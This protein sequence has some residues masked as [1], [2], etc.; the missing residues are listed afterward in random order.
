M[1]RRKG[2]TTMKK[3]LCTLLAAVM[4]ALCLLTPASAASMPKLFP[5]KVTGPNVVQSYVPNQT[6]GTFYMAAYD[7]TGRMVGFTAHTPGYDS[8]DTVYLTASGDIDRVEFFLLGDN[9]APLTESLTLYRR[10][11]SL[12]YDGDSP[13]TARTLYRKNLDKTF[14]GTMNEAEV[15]PGDLV[16][17]LANADGSVTAKVTHYELVQVTS[18]GGHVTLNWNGVSVSIVKKLFAR[19]DYKAGDYV[20]V[21]FNEDYTRVLDSY[22]TGTVSGKVTALKGGKFKIGS[23]FYRNVSD[24]EISLFDTVTVVLNRANQI[25]RV[26][27]QTTG[28][29]PDN[30]NPDIPGSSVVA[31]TSILAQLLDRWYYVYEEEDGTLTYT[32]TVLTGG[33]ELALTFL[34]PLDLE[35]GD[36]FTYTL[37]K[38]GKAIFVEKLSS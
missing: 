38:Y 37:N 21:A 4:A 36:F 1:C 26:L 24:T 30:P 14:S 22:K 23:E 34:A 18:V 6:E 19:F 10:L 29:S 15:L 16:E 35:E 32:Y 31:P 8:L 13:S 5:I 17:Y 7:D 2:A 11:G 20:L 28:Q 33:D 25:T 12:I 3:R 9:H 27:E